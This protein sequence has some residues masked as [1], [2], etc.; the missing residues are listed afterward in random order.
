MRNRL[1]SLVA[2]GLIF[3]GGPG[4]VRAATIDCAP[5]RL[6]A[7]VDSSVEDT[8]KGQANILLRSLGSGSVENGYRQ[9]ESDT[10]AR[11]PGADKLLL[12]REYI[13]VS[14]T[15]LAASSHWSDDQKWDKWMQLMNRWSAAPPTDSA[16]APAPPS[17]PQPPLSAE[18]PSA[19]AVARAATQ[20]VIGGVELG[21]SLAQIQAR[22]DISLS[23]YSD[24]SH[25]G[26]ETF[27]FTYGVR[28]L[29][30]DVVF[31]LRG[32]AVSS[33]TVTHTL[34]A[35]SCADSATAAIILN[36]QIHDWGAPLR[37][38]V[39]AAA[40]GTGGET[41]SYTFRRD[42]VDMV[43]VLQTSLRAD[44]A[45]LCRVSMNYQRSAARG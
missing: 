22:K 43:L 40:A 32:D 17:P 36:E 14:C 39:P 5:L 37:R 19:G 35:A 33:I 23:L 28:Q 7:P 2:V 38:I 30:G 4:Q 42:G 25:Y 1:C 44:G 9:V 41:A 6:G 45:S 27:T 26:E 24:G 15:L 18:T 20:L 29:D 34:G 8:I 13:Y 12:W 10:L 21:T 31:G 11:Y 16:P 3:C